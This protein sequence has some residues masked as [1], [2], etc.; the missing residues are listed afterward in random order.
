MT[1]WKR[2]ERPENVRTIGDF[3]IYSARSADR[4]PVLVHSGAKKAPAPRERPGAWRDLQR[5]PLMSERTCSIEDCDRPFQARGY[6]LRH[7]QKYCRPPCSI[8]GCDKP[9]NARGWCNNHYSQW[10]KHGD[11]LATLRPN[12]SEGTPEERFWEKIDKT[13]PP[14]SHAPEMGSCWLWTDATRPEP[15]SSRYGT[16]WVVDRLVGAHRF[17]YELLVGPIPD[18]LVIDHLCRIPR[19]VNPSHLEPVTAAE[20][21]RRAARARYGT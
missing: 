4:T 14:P 6:C 9:V 21:A 12:R 7:Y 13:G 2:D 10:Q 11:P 17:S 18:G 1:Q 5:R 15:W 19:C 3:T 16:L 20:N 8:E